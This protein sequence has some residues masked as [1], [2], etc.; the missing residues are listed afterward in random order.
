MAT[1]G[2]FADHRMISYDASDLRRGVAVFNTTPNSYG[3]SFWQAGRAPAI[4]DA[5]NIFAVTGNGEFNGASDFS[6]SVLKLSGRDL[7]VLDWYTL[8]T[9]GQTCAIAT[10]I[11]VQLAQFSFPEPIKFSPQASPATCYWS[12]PLTWNMSER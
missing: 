4:D 2:I 3:G 1:D 6:G 7:S 11:S 12:I 9:T 10:R 8:P 5:G